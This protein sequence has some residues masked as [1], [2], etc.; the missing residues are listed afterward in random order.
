MKTLPWQKG[1]SPLMLAPMQGLTNRAMRAVQCDIGQPDVVFTEFVR[2]SHVA[3]QRIT[4]SDR[5]EIQADAAGVPLVVQLIGHRSESLAEAAEI[6]AD[7][8]GRHV[9]INMGCPFGRTTTG[10]TGG[11][12]LQEPEK[13]VDCLRAVR[14]VFDGSLSVKVR[15]GYEDPEQIFDVLPVFEDC[16][17]DFIVLHPRTVVQKYAGEAD[18]AITARVVAGTPLPVI[19]NGDLFTSERARQVARQTGAAG[20]M[21]GRGAIADPWLFPRIRCHVASPNATE[22]LHQMTVYF[23]RLSERYMQLFCGERQVLSKLKNV[24]DAF[25]DP[26]LQPLIKKLRRCK[27]LSQF[28]AVLNAAALDT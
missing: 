17:V 23:N 15:A 27:Q 24:L 6:V 3:R 20:L 16:G 21:L 12:M 13:I 26:A 11:A 10:K 14:A 25:V 9:N 28:H 4:A 2:V 8:G 5:R 19:A 22:Y 18:H 7:L 1:T